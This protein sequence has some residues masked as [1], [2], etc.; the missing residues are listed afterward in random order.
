VYGLEA[1][2]LKK[3]PP[4]PVHNMRAWSR[5]ACRRAADPGGDAVF[6]PSSNLD[7]LFALFAYCI[8]QTVRHAQSLRREASNQSPALADSLALA[9]VKRNKRFLGGHPCGLQTAATR[10]PYS[11]RRTHQ[12]HF[13]THRFVSIA[14]DLFEALGSKVLITVSYW[15]VVPSQN[16]HSFQPLESNFNV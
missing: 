4:V 12:R 1:F 6:E 13:S 14:D 8:A 10:R 9:A 2:F 16:S 5:S 3:N 15:L 11:A 7:G